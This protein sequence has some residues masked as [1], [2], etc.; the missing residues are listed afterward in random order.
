[1]N[2][3]FDCGTPDEF[4]NHFAAVATDSAYNIY[5]IK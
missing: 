3:V 2:H 4:N 5:S 1:M